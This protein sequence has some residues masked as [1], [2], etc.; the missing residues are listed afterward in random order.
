MRRCLLL[1]VFAV[2]ATLVIVVPLK[3]TYATSGCC[4]WHGGVSYCDSSVGTYVCND[5]TYSPSCGCYLA[6]A[7]PV[8]NIPTIGNNG[9]F[10]FT[11]NGC[12]HD[13]SFTWDKG[14]GDAYYSLAIS[15]IKGGDP[16]P[17]SDTNTSEFVFK[18]VSTGTW[19]INVKPGNSC[20]WGTVSYWTVEVPDATPIINISKEKVTGNKYILKYNITCATKATITPDIGVIPT[21]NNMVTVEPKNDQTYTVTAVNKSKE[22]S[23]DVQIIVDKEVLDNPETKPQEPVNTQVTTPVKDPSPAKDNIIVRILKALGIL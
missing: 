5:G 18:N 3:I 19:Y 11:Q 2:V 17:L 13:V 8:C 6:P 12:T 23:A 10:N 14:V 9:S 15:K 7:K 16:G 22:G 4:S 20:G 21:G 1:S